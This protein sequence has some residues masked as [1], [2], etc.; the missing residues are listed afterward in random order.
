MQ[1][2]RLSGSL[3]SWGSRWVGRG[4]ARMSDPQVSAVHQSEGGQLLKGRPGRAS[5][6]SQGHLGSSLWVQ[7][8]PWE[9]VQGSPVAVEA[10]RNG[11]R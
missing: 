5:S 9:H 1:T 4:R 8:V 10:E 11:W 3:E 7:P 6:S 2:L